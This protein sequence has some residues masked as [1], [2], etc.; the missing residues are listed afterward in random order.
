M[1]RFESKVVVITGAT[2]G[3]GYVTAKRFAAE[4]ANVACVGRNSERGTALINQILA[5]SGR[6]LFLRADVRNNEQVMAVVDQV[7]QR[8]GRIDVLFN[9]AGVE[10]IRECAETT[11]EEWDLTLD[12]NLK[13]AFLFSKYSIPWLKQSRGNIVNNASSIGL[14]GSPNY[15]AYCASKGG[16]VLFTK[17]LALECAPWKI[18]VNCICPG[19]INTPMLDREIAHFPDKEAVVRSITE[20]A[21][22][23]RIA[24]PDEV[25]GVVLFLASDE[26]SYVTGASYSVD[27]GT[28][29]K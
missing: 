8:F 9:N 11:E 16:L 26:A 24:T 20:E 5:D 2:A 17:A 19:A 14:V 10:L 29:A 13:S 1:K 27:G 23:R 3:I 21:P 28:T 25:A 6:A 4:G 12:T 18:R 15:T 22:L 7:A